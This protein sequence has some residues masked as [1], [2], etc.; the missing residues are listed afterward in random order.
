[1]F[2]F[3]LMSYTLLFSCHYFMEEVRVYKCKVTMHGVV[4]KAGIRRRQ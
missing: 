2:I 4:K 3:S 1:M